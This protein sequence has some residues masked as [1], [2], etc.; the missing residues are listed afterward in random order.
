MRRHERWT[1]FA[2]MTI[3][4]LALSASGCAGG[5]DV[6]G[7]LAGT[8]QGHGQC[9]D[10]DGQ[11]VCDCDE[12][13]VGAT[14][15]SCAPGHQ[16][17]DG[18]GE[19][20]PACGTEGTD[21]AEHE[22]C[23]DGSGEAR[24]ICA[25]AYAGE[26]C[27]ECAE[28]YQDNDEDGSCLPDCDNVAFDCGALGV[29]SDES[30]QA[31][32]DCIEGYQ[33]N[34]FDGACQADCDHVESDCGEH[35][36]CDDASGTATCH[37]EEAYAGETCQFCA[38]GYQDLDEDGLCLPSCDLLGL[39]CGL[40]GACMDESGE[41]HCVCEAEYVGAFCDACAVNYQD[42]DADGVCSV[43][44]A[45]VDCMPHS[46]CE[47][48]SGTALCVCFVGY[49]E[50]D[51]TSCS[52]GY[53]DHDGDGACWPS[54]V[55]VNLDCG[56]HGQCE[57]DSGEAI[58]E[59]FPAYTGAS[60]Q[61]CAM[62]YQDHDENG[63]CEPDC[64]LAGLVCAAHS[65]CE[66]NSGEA[67]CVCDA[68]YAEPD[69]VACAEGYQD[70]DGD[71]SCLPTCEALAW[72]C[73]GHGVCGYEN[74]QAVCICDEAGGF[75][76]DGL[77]NCIGADAGHDCALPLELDLSVA[78]VT[79]STAG[80]G[81]DY[82]GSCQNSGS[83]DEMVYHFELSESLTITFDLSGSSYDT[84][85]YLRSD[86]TN[87]SSEI[88]CDDDSG[89]GLDSM[90]EVDLQPG[91]FYL[92]ID[93]YNNSVG[94]YTLTL[95]V[96]CGDGTLYY[97][98]TGE[99]LPDPCVSNP[100][101]QTHQTLC[102]PQLPDS[103]LCLCDPGYIFDSSEPPVCIL[104]PNPHGESCADVMPLSGNSGMVA[105]SSA[106]A[107][108]D[109][110]GSCA[111]GGPDRVYGMTLDER[112][113]VVLDLD[114]L[115]NT[116]TVLH[117]RSVC[118][119]AAS[120]VACD[121]DGG[122]GLSSAL[123]LI[124]DAGAYFIWADSYSEGGDYELTYSMNPDP[125]ADEEVVCPGNPICEA[126]TDWSGYDCVCGAGMLPFGNDCVPDPC[127]D[128]VCQD[129]EHR[130]RCVPNEADGYA[131]YFCECNAGY[132]DDLD[133]PPAC[134][135]DPDANDWAFIVF[136]NADNNLESDGYDDVDEMTVAG[137]TAH[138]HIVTLF[139]TLY[140]DN[141]DA[142]ILYIEQ[143]GTTLVEN[144]NEVDM[145]DWRTLRDFGVWAVEHYPARHY[146]MIMWDHGDGWKAA[147]KN[148]LL[149]GFSNDDSGTAGEISI[150]NGDYASAM[151][152]IVAAAGTKL[153]IVGFDACLMGMWEVAEASAPYANYLVA[154]SE[155]E[156][157]AGWPYHEFLPGLVADYNMAA[158]DLG[159]SIVDAY[160]NESSD[161]STLAVTD[162]NSMD[163]LAVAMDAFASELMNNTGLYGTISS[164]RSNTQSF[165]FS[166]F[167]DL[168]GFAE[169][170]AVMST[171]PAALQQ[172]AQALVDQLEVTIVYSRAQSG[173]SG[174][175]GLS[176]YFPSSSDSMD[177][178]YRDSGAIWTRTMWDEF[179]V[180]FTQ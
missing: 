15:G 32:C 2:M 4:V 71:G 34:D 167:K 77:G 44:C 18:D 38:E 123:T 158:A 26:N 145:S 91:D 48:N 117:V 75:F 174:S 88:A 126:W 93:G 125:C 99:C 120:E 7:C 119:S 9:A 166:E 1:A 146:A 156:P 27:D 50:P 28:A 142:R 92:F 153:D 104:D 134:I 43:S 6:G 139:D 151:A 12:G 73:S 173:Y 168:Q 24:C 161:N 30:G 66:D 76:P 112:S 169:G 106:T 64:N 53:Q 162:L 90:F 140:G 160:S 22:V 55:T 102:D 100:C 40:H 45:L 152:G 141:G 87:A 96:G 78:S 37:C 49:A 101:Q 180:S 25:E 114:G 98:V 97:P 130:N 94:N 175:N 128:G 16:D 136:L 19:C 137:S 165:T 54:C 79:G 118:D 81:D 63:E 172:A 61:L 51:C 56:E 163:D 116:D 155:T 124:L 31:R 105:G 13:Y 157:V 170:V 95:D 35:G 41:A 17:H 159:I 42:H 83:A 29:C 131:T 84:M 176:I 69:C 179:L 23:D 108:D 135:M 148:P 86:C 70:S 3:L 110:T 58:C 67:Q 132:I 36:I 82:V 68:G 147:P 20:L 46:A 121:D 109:A 60:C 122:S 39:D 33:D 89:D 8:C 80:G 149:K 127:V 65:H 52:D 178:A 62:D 107:A 111:G 57:D 59:C 5:E 177:P 72:T 154:S 144:W 164:V 85:M 115:G 113:L 133:N 11:A 14:C 150:S 129:I 103:Y 138:V 171:A 10:V 143:G 74:G 47:D 21:C